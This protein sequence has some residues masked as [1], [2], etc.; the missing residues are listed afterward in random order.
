MTIWGRLGIERTKDKRKIR[1]AYAE[2]AAQY[3]QEEHP[4]EFE[5]INQ[6]YQEA[7]SYASKPVFDEDLDAVFLEELAKVTLPRQSSEEE[8]IQTRSTGW[9]FH[10]LLAVFFLS[11]GVLGLWK[12]TSSPQEFMRRLMFIIILFV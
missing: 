2:L 6:A 8:V 12:L 5:E 7:L 1:H 11:F 4:E 10:L 3:H 9:M